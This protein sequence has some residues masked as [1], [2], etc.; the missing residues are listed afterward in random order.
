ML[1]LIARGAVRKINNL[2]GDVLAE[3][4]VHEFR[5]RFLKN[6]INPL[7]DAGTTYRDGPAKSPTALMRLR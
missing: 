7:I 4:M 5:S 1:K 3:D 6:V 2:Y